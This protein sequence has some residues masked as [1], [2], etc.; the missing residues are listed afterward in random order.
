MLRTDL[1]KVTLEKTI[2]NDHILFLFTLLLWFSLSAGWVTPFSSPMN[3][4]WQEISL[5]TLNFRIGI[6]RITLCWNVRCQSKHTIQTE[7]NSQMKRLPRLKGNPVESQKGKLHVLVPGFGA[8]WGICR[9]S[10]CSTPL[11][12]IGKW[13]VRC[14]NHGYLCLHSSPLHLQQ[15]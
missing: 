12:Q 4:L 7:P 14:Y 1:W 8:K 2:L 11:L 15:V 9:H 5:L 13:R 3:R 10:L 6:S